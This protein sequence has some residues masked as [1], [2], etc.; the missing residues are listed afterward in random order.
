M[1]R[2]REPVVT[3]AE[4]VK[5]G[6]AVV[7]SRGERLTVRA[8]D[9]DIIHVSH[10]P[11][12]AYPVSKT[13]VVVG[14]EGGERPR[15]DHGNLAA[16][17][18]AEPEIHIEADVQAKIE[19]NTRSL[20]VAMS[21]NVVGDSKRP[22]CLQWYSSETSTSET[23]PAHTHLFAQDAVLGAYAYESPSGKGMH[24]MDRQSSKE[25]YYGVGEVTG[26]LNR[27]G[28][29]FQLACRDAMGY[30]A[31]TSDPLYKNFPYYITYNKEAQVAYGILYDQLCGGYLDLGQEISAFRGSFR[32]YASEAGFVDYYLILGPTIPQVVEKLGRLVGRPAVPPAWALGY[33]A[34]TMTYADAPDAQRRLEAFPALCEQHAMPCNGFYLSSGYTMDAEGNRNVFTWNRNRVPEPEKMLDTFHA[35]KMGV[36][37]NVKPWLLQAHPRYQDMKSLGGFFRTDLDHTTISPSFTLGWFWKGGPGTF[38]SGSYLDFSNPVAFQWWKKQLTE[39]LLEPGVDAVWND[40]NEYELDDDGAICHENDLPIGILGRTLQPLLMARA[41]FEALCELHPDKRP[42]VVSRSGCLGISRYAA[43]TWSG[44]NDTSFHTLKWNIPMSLGLSL[45]GWVGCGADIG[46]FT[47][48]AVTPELFVRWIQLGIYM[49]RFSIHSSSWKA[50]SQVNMFDES[51]TQ[52]STLPATH[53]ASGYNLDCTNEPWM[54]PEMTSTVRSLLCLRQRLLPLLLS[55]HIEA[56]ATNAPVM[57]PLVYHYASDRSERSR[58]ESFEFLLGRDLLVAAVLEAKQES[59]LVYFPGDVAHETWC[60]LHTGL[61]YGGGTEATVEAPLQG[62][63][64]GAPIFLRNGSGF[65]LADHNAPRSRTLILA[66]Q[67]SH[68]TQ[69]INVDWWE[70]PTKDQQGVFRDLGDAARV[71]VRAVATPTEVRVVSIEKFGAPAPIDTLSFKL[72]PNDARAI[73]CDVSW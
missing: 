3:D 9:N 48:D 39:Q 4:V 5:D 56:W 32:T 17:G 64:F 18:I 41:S 50:S 19:L 71:T 60:D 11:Y 68:S 12:G 62:R 47:G 45:C 6:F 37:A 73:I 21:T 23:P 43:Q 38:A 25:F 52:S 69:E 27:A 51:N 15:D 31:A 44:D 70:D 33:V 16:S 63:T 49:A 14:Q 46:G 40:N 59:R 1:Q 28:R 34:S 53:D 26:E 55:L 57:R 54:F 10:L 36:I 24:R 29:R 66:A 58:L 65:V 35:R 67:Q 61:W 72:V 7:G 30:D 42:L 2:Y 13:W 20:R 22:F 8:V